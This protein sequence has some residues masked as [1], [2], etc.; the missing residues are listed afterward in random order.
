MT[1]N[2]ADISKTDLGCRKS[3][4]FSP[5]PQSPDRPLLKFNKKESFFFKIYKRRQ[6]RQMFP[7]LYNDSSS[8]GH[9]ALLCPVLHPNSV[10]VLVHGRMRLDERFVTRLS[11]VHDEDDAQP[12]SHA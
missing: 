11:A 12:V 3:A 4:Q 10:A 5:I 9:H 1:R 6:H 7:L 2:G 8:D